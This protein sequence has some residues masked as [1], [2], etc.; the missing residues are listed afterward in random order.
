MLQ[1]G[2][3]YYTKLRLSCCASIANDSSASNNILGEFFFVNIFSFFLFS[4]RERALV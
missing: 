4:Q 2:F 1:P 3:Q